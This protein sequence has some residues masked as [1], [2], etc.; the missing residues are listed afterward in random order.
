MIIFNRE[1]QEEKKVLI[2]IVA[3]EEVYNLL[4][5]KEKFFKI[6]GKNV[7]YLIILLWN[8]SNAKN[9]IIL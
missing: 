3:D 6:L 9:I 2:I 1:K 7:L 8:V 4:L 5:K